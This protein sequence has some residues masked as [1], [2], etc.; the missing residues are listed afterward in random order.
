MIRELAQKKAAYEEQLIHE[1]EQT[2]QVEIRPNNEMGW[3]KEL[4][5][6]ES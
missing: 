1:H 2:N 3:L 5:L 6:K 4:H